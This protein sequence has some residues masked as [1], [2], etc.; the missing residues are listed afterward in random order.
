MG[1]YCGRYGCIAPRHMLLPHQA[2]ARL[3][4]V[5][6]IASIREPAF[7]T[8]AFLKSHVLSM[9]NNDSAHGHRYRPDNEH[10]GEQSHLLEGGQR[11]QEVHWIPRGRMRQQATGTRYC[12]PYFASASTS[13][14]RILTHFSAFWAF[15]IAIDRSG[16]RALWLQTAGR[17][18]AS[19]TGS[20]QTQMLTCSV[21]Q[22]EEGNPAHT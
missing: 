7:S 17:M 8:F 13:P 11:F 15:K 22:G 4:E 2:E 16:L 14:V 1:N 6:M 10:C 5:S 9:S 3:G 20:L 12:G 21:K 19:T 18:A